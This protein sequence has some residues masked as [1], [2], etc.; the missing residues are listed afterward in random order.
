MNKQERTTMSVREMGQ[1]L[2]LGKTDSYWLVHR[3]H[4]ETTLVQGVMRVNIES[5]EHWYANQIKYKKIDGTPPGEELRAY[6]YSVAEM[7]ELLDVSIDIAY[8]LLKRCDIETF[9]V[10]T[11]M[12]IRKDVFERW[13]RSQTKYRTKEDRERD[14]ERERSSMT[15]P[16]MAKLLGIT[17]DE[18]YAIIGKKKN[19]GIFDIIVVADKNASPWKALKPGTKTRIIIR[20]YQGIRPVCSVILT[21]WMTQNI[22]L[23]FRMSAVALLQEKPLC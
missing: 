20:R 7:A 2:G 23:C 12:R 5:F 9:T 17:R 21:R 16:Q 1:M 22:E 19:R 11:W 4:F 14:A 6:S 10:D 18:V 13:Y 3:K 8:S 15:F